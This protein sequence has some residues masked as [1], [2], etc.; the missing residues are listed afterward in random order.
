LRNRIVE[1]LLEETEVPAPPAMVADE[2]EKRLGRF[3]RE[4]DRAKIDI[5]RYVEA[6]KITKEELVESYRKAAERSVAAD[7]LLDSI[8]DRQQINVSHD[9]LHVDLDQ[10]AEQLDQDVEKLEK[11]LAKRGRLGVLAQDIRRR[12]TLDYLVEHAKVIEEEPA[13]TDNKS[14]E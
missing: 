7:L 5:D 9:E 4:L 12:K 11:D 6:N 1:R 2:T 8:A 10:M 3:L 14:K 13:S